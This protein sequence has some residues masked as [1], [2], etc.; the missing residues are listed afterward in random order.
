MYNIPELKQRL[1]IIKHSAL[2]DAVILDE[3]YIQLIKETPN[4][5][6]RE[7]FKV[8]HSVVQHRISK[9]LDSNGRHQL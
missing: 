1:I 4:S 9:L 7:Q 6:E 8:L 2:D 3:N 5:D